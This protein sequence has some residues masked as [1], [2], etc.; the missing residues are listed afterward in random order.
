MFEVSWQLYIMGGLYK[1]VKLSGKGCII[2]MTTYIFFLSNFKKS[3]QVCVKSESILGAFSS[4]LYTQM[5]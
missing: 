3:I 1:V 2:K 5:R 4:V